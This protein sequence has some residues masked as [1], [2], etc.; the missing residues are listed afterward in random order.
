[1]TKSNKSRYAILGML[2]MFPN[3]SGYDIKKLMEESTQHFWKETFGSIYPILQALQKERLITQKENPTP[4]GRMRILYALT[5]KGKKT[6]QEWLAKTAEKEPYRHE[7]L[8]KLFF[9]EFA[10]PALIEKH[11]EEYR[12]AL[13]TKLAL[14]EHIKRRLLNEEKNSPSLPYWLL[15]LDY[16]LKQTGSALEW[17]QESLKT[18]RKL[19]KE[20]AT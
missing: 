9:G 19:I 14:F 2:G 1:M 18:I 8:L 15:T 10:P 6:L 4:S 3:S 13:S 7:L 11:L 5:T 12:D 20:N 16:G 17:C